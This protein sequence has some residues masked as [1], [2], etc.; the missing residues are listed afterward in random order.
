MIPITWNQATV[1]TELQDC[2]QQYVPIY[3]GKRVAAD[4]AL[5]FGKQLLQRLT[6]PDPQIFAGRQ[7]DLAHDM[8][9]PALFIDLLGTRWHNVDA[10]QLQDV[11]TS[12]MVSILV[13]ENDLNAESARDFLIGAS[14]YADAVSW[15]IRSQFPDYACDTA[16]VTE[17]IPTRT[18][19][20]PAIQMEGSPIW[21]RVI[22]VECMVTHRTTIERYL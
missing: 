11:D 8:V 14:V 7:E 22:T 6:F 2:L 16:G 3:I 20:S 10:S 17:S 1:L 9:T 4:A 18:P 13:S 5:P 12:V 19:L 21:L 15:T